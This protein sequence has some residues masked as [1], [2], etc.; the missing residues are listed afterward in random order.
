MPPF[1]PTSSLTPKPVPQDQQK[2]IRRQQIH[3]LEHGLWA[4]FAGDAL[5]SPSHWFYGGFPQVQQYYGVEGITDYT[6]PVH[7]LAGSILNKSNLS[8]A[9]RSA[10]YNTGSSKQQETIVGHVINHGKQEY[11]DP[12]KQI[13][14]HATLQAGE[15]TLEASL[16]R[17]LMRSLTATKGRLDVDHFRAAYV[18]FMTTPG[19]HND[20]YAS[21]C[22]RMFFANLVY[23][24]KLPRDCP[25]NDAH[26][27][28]TV[29]GLVL[30][31]II[32]LSSAAAWD[33][34]LEQAAVDAAAC[35]AVT[36][37]SRVVQAAAAAWA[38]V[39]FE[40]VRSHENDTTRLTQRA[41]A[42][43]VRMKYRQPRASGHAVTACYLDSAVPALLDSIVTYDQ[44][45]RQTDK[46]VSFDQVWQGLLANANSGGEN[47]HKGSCLGAILGADADSSHDWKSSRLVRGLYNHKELELEIN[48]LVETIR[49]REVCDM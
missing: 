24:H 2:K 44:Q 39:V 9:G 18:A 7:D 47:V 34:T 5:A 14:Y 20:T 19:S 29:D 11:W 10:A 45:Q 37:N 46:C 25:D 40:T 17:V 3:R 42:M 1:A 16:A 43:A 21:T 28:D 33:G 38:R 31:T 41:E 36:R 22:H 32:A 12:A 13:H 30:P 23:Q 49:S 8:G 35:V 27:V 48:S 15:E 6:K 26:N 4:F